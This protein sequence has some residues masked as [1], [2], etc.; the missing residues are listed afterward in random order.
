MS[1][2]ASASTS[3]PSFST[4]S[5]GGQLSLDLTS[6]TVTGPRTPWATP[7]EQCVIINLPSSSSTFSIT[8]Q[9]TGND[10]DFETHLGFM[11]H[12][13][14][15]IYEGIDVS[16]DS[17]FAHGKRRAPLARSIQVKE[18][19][20]VEFDQHSRFTFSSNESTLLVLENSFKLP[21]AIRLISPS[22][23]WSIK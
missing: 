16:K 9:S 13:L 12:K 6:T 4:K 21:L 11:D 17:I 10:P 3:Y 15:I 22:Q 1:E 5:L 20:L 7:K 8:L 18:S 14:G 2:T 23:S 19:I